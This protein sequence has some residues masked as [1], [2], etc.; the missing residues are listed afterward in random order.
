VHAGAEGQATTGVWINPK[1]GLATPE[2]AAARYKAPFHTWWIDE[3]DPIREEPDWR[4]R[5]FL[6]F[7]EEWSEALESWD[8]MAWRE[9]KRLQPEYIRRG[10]DWRGGKWPAEIPPPPSEPAP[11]RVESCTDLLAAYRMGLQLRPNLNLAWSGSHLRRLD[12]HISGFDTCL[13]LTHLARLRPLVGSFEDVPAFRGDKATALRLSPVVYG[14]TPDDHIWDYLGAELADAPHEEN[15]RKIYGRPHVTDPIVE[16]SWWPRS[17]GLWDGVGYSICRDE[18]PPPALWAPLVD[19]YCRSDD[20]DLAERYWSVMA[21]GDIKEV[22]GFPFAPEVVVEGVGVKHILTIWG[23]GRLPEAEGL[24]LVIMVQEHWKG[25]TSPPH[26][27]PMVLNY[28]PDLDLFRLINFDDFNL[29]LLD[30][31]P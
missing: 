21:Q 12:L 17:S 7:G 25:G 19:A 4:E 28:D 3:D 5:A 20:P 18:A 6:L 27:M 26:W 22:A 30:G 13:A 31:V 8:R 11:Q 24:V 9:L 16:G 23:V 2:E 10:G 29:K 14:W 15:A 1:L